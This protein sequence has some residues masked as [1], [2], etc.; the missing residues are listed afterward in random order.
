MT[1]ILYLLSSATMHSSERV[2]CSRKDIMVFFLF[3]FGDAIFIL[4]FT[5]EA[6]CALDCDRAV[7]GIAIELESLKLCVLADVDKWHEE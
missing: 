5:N 2:E 6:N 4:L 3:N 1:F 7:L